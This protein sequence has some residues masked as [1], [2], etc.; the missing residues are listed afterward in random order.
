[1]PDAEEANKQW[2][3]N[4]GGVPVNH[5]VI[6]RE[7][8]AKERPDVVAE[9]F[10]VFKEARQ[11]DTAAPKGALDP[12][13]FGVEANRASLERVI[14]YSFKQQMIPRKFTVDELFDDV[15]RKLGA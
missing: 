1:V 3:L 15:T 9:L 8:I 10:R 5:M 2:A 7:K 12:Y 4:H 6:V 11:L 13:R 14:D